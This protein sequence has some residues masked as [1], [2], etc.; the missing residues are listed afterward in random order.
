[1]MNDPVTRPSVWKRM[2]APVFALVSLIIVFVM[3]QLLAG[4]AVLLLAGSKVTEE[5]ASF[6]RWATVISQLFCILLP[7]L[8]LGR[9]RFGSLGAAFTMK[10]PG[11]RQTILSVLA[12]FALQQLLQVYMVLQDA[13]PL[14]PKVKELIDLVNALYEQAYRVLGTAHSPVEFLIVVLT[15]A[16]V[17]AVAEE[18]LFRGL[19][20]HSVEESSNGLRAAIAS[21]LIFG[22]YHLNPW[23]IV[24]LV[25]LGTFFGYLVYRSRNLSVAISAHFFN[26]FVAC[27][28]SYMNV[29]DDFI[30]LSPSAPATGPLLLANA[31]FFLLVFVGATYYFVRVSEEGSHEEH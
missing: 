29:R 24:P 22:A 28:A 23:S 10:I 11:A 4:G 27:A 12:V 7:A 2:P 19:I 16:L 31:S 14:P 6:I 20:Q 25:A 18:V 5:N 30:A 21:G 26:N 15:V 17:P 1:M 3:Y 13:I 9:L 8:F